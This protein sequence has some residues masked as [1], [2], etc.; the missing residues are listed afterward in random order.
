MPAAL[1]SSFNDSPMTPE[2]RSI[3]SVPTSLRSWAA[4]CLRSA[5]ICACAAAV[6]RAA[7]RVAWSFC[8][9]TIRLPSSRACSLIAAASL[10]ASASCAVYWSS[11][12]SALFWA[13]SA[14]AMFPSMAAARSSSSLTKLG[15][16]FHT[17][18]PSTTTKQSVAQTRSD[19]S[20]RSGLPCSAAS[21]TA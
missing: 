9:A 1:V 18:N 17:K 4:A 19:V 14:F 3:A 7:S 6:T 11:S 10:R 20:G 12:A 2:A 21:V 15:M 8:C 5:S 16:N 13:S